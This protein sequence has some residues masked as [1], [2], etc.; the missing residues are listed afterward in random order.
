MKRLPSKSINLLYTNPPFGTTTNAWDEK[1]DWPTYFKEAFRLLKE[2]G[3]I[4]IHC[5]VPFNYQLIREAPKPPTY[6]WY[7]KKEGQT[8][9]LLANVQ[10][11]RDTEEILV[12]KNK[13]ITYYRQQVGDEERVMPW[14]TNNRY[15]NQT[16]KEGKTVLKG[17]TR[18]H[19]IEMKRD[20]QGFS[21][22]PKEIVELMIASY[23]KP[24]DVVL[25]TFCYKGLTGKTCK[26]MDRRSISI[27][28]N[29][30]PDWMFHDGLHDASP[31]SRSS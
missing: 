30:Y 20:I 8:T 24:G 21:T 28:K 6:S 4:V 9:P 31:S 14:S 12:W 19:F 25:D 2:D 22:R 26:E 11:L 23:T 1:I 17:K 5:S 7:W 18:T 29:F 10:P 13:K 27:D 15:V 3:M 16:L